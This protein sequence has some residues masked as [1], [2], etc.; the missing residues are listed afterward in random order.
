MQ[1][2]ERT[3]SYQQ[4]NDRYKWKM[5]RMYTKHERNAGRFVK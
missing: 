2:D 4:N 1:N 5:N 3:K